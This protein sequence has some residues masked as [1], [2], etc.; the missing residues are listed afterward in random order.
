AHAN[1]RT[2][3]DAGVLVRTLEL[4]QA[5]DVDARLAGIEIFGGTHDDT[6]RIDLVDDAAAAGADGG[7][8]VTGNDRLHAGADERRFGANQRHRLALHVRAHQRAVGVIVLEERNERRG[9]RNQ[10]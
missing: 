7:A 5:I 10:L 4:H 8:R 3:V 9:D 2:L 6:R 1:Q